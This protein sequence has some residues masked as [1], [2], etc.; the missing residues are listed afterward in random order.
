[1]PHPIPPADLAEF[2]QAKASTEDA[3]DQI[4]ASYRLMAG[5][6]ERPEVVMIAVFDQMRNL[7][8]PAKLAQVLVVA[9]ARLAELPV[10][11]T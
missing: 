10:G 9:V 4:V 11:D 5:S 3:L 6:G 1:M 7:T 8:S 2:D